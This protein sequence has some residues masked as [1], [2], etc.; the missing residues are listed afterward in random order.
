MEIIQE[1]L[2]YPPEKSL[3]VTTVNPIS[4]GC[5]LYKNVHDICELFDFSDY[6]ANSIKKKI[7][8]QIKKIMHIYK[9]PD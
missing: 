4:T 1:L 7:I 5:L 2:D 9:H 8:V 3:F 6:T